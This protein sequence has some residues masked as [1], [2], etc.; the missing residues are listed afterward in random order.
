[1][2]STDL[3]KRSVSNVRGGHHPEDIAMMANSIKH[4]GI[5]NPPTVALN[6]D[7][8]YEI[9]AGQ[10]RVAGAIAAGLTEIN[11]LDVSVLTEAE[12]VELSLAENMDRR[13]MT[14]IELFKA[15]ATLF[16]AG[17]SVPK[18]SEKF[19]KTED[20]VQQH[21]AIGTLP[22]KILDLAEKGE[23]GSRTI[24]A[25]AIAPGKDVTRYMKL[26]VNERP[27]DWNIE[28]WLRGENGWFREGYAIF[29]L[30]QYVGPKITDLFSENEVWY[31][32]GAQFME[33]Q[34]KAVI[35]EIE[36]LQE[37]GWTVNLLER[38]DEWAYDKTA[39]KD[40]AEVFYTFNRRTGK[41][42]FHKGYK[43]KPKTGNAPKAKDA[44]GE[45]EKK[46]EVSK[47]FLAY[48][49]EIRHADVQRCMVSQR[50]AGLVATLIVLLKECG[51]VSFGHAGYAVKKD[52]F[53]ESINTDASKLIIRD[54][55]QVM[56]DELGIPSGSLWQLGGKKLKEAVSQ[57]YDLTPA[58][59]IR[60]IIT[61]VAYKWDANSNYE[62]TDMVAGALGLTEVGIWEGDDAF[63]DGITNKETLIGIAKELD[64]PID[65]K[66]TAK[67]LRSV[68]RDKVPAEWRPKWLTYE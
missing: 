61:C 21:L 12:R 50:Q 6:G 36:K 51:N 60:Y 7:G 33:L 55:F 20:E 49:G 46:P 3:L 31:V 25:L 30:D 23:I 54:D 38:F 37:L 14:A 32:D 58:T 41:V 68:I 44:G 34:E 43:R 16:K 17:V 1:M 64:I 11:C 45:P 65:E 62:D 35:A 18:I 57:F 5:I 52:A 53:I 10:L 48:M 40:G 29:E 2:I 9:I 15:F 66:A 4:R 47:E 59:L 26:K 8:K 27:N 39:K 19:G 24:K 42:S 13:D 63:W 56:C 22:K 67:V 28:Q